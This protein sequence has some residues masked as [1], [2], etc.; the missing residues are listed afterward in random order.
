[1]IK[2]FRDLKVTDKF[3]FVGDP[4]KDHSEGRDTEDVYMK[5]YPMKHYGFNDHMV[6]AICLDDGSYTAIADDEKV[7]HGGILW[8]ANRYS[9]PPITN[10]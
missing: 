4:T 5:I 2:K 6:N 3:T 1:M 7:I 8:V 9:V 10:P